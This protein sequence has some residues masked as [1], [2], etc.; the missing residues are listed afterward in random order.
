MKNFYPE[1]FFQI[2]YA[3]RLTF[4]TKPPRMFYSELFNMKQ[5]SIEQLLI[6][7]S[8]FKQFYN[9][10]M[11]TAAKGKGGKSSVCCKKRKIGH[12]LRTLDNMMSRNLMA[13]ARERGVDEL[14]AM[15]G[16]ILG[17]LCRNEDKD[18]F[19]KDIEA[20]FKICRSTVT[21][22]LKLMEKKGYIRRESV[23]YD[24]RLKKLV[25]TDTGRELHEKTKDMIDILEEQ[26]IEG[27][28]K[29]D[30]DTFYRVIDQLKSNVKNMLGET[31]C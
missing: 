20:E 18:I 29:E 5:S 23:P 7:Q 3:N 22:I 10:Q 4:P 15:H 17:Y 8:L 16:W 31:S 2:F 25:L 9:E 26:T 11:G 6:E 14:T 13:A 30:L 12:E 1:H 27:I 24:A 19:Q 28:A 21:N